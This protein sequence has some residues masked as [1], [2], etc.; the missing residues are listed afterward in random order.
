MLLH[1]LKQKTFLGIY[2]RPQPILKFI[3][4]F[5]LIWYEMPISEKELTA[6]RKNCPIAEF[7]N[8]RRSIL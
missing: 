8:L 6:Y 2:N 1:E 5:F 7:A 3:I 4:A